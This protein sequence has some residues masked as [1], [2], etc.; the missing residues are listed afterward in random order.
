MFSSPVFPTYW[1]FVTLL[2]GIWYSEV[3][4]QIT[5]ICNVGLPLWWMGHRTMC[6]GKQEAWKCPCKWQGM[7]VSAGGSSWWSC[8]SGNFCL[9]KCLT[10]HCSVVILWHTEVVCRVDS[11]D[12][13]LYI[14]SVVLVC[15]QRKELTSY[16][17]TSLWGKSGP[18]GKVNNSW[19][20]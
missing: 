5:M 15:P 18:R 9:G 1:G 12:Y 8:H 2:R 11:G 4:K 3:N 13:R 19:N 10:L 14:Y 7:L 17:E 16:M 20:L 6:M